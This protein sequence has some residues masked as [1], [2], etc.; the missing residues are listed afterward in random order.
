MRSIVV[1]ALW[2]VGAFGFTEFVADYLE[3]WQTKR[4]PMVAEAADLSGTVAA[5]TI[6]FADP[7]PNSR[8]APRPSTRSNARQQ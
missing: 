8:P 2:L 7:G 5:P 1:A 6:H 3:T 4:S